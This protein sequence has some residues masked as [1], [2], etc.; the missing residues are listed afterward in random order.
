[1][2]GFGRGSFSVEGRALLFIQADPGGD[3]CALLT[4]LCK[5][6][7]E[8]VSGRQVV[9][10][11]TLCQSRR[12]ALC[13]WEAQFVDAPVDLVVGNTLDPLPQHPE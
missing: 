2:G 9:V 1:M 5:G 6:A 4:G 12:D 3:A 7:I 11:H 8:R 13:R 10:S